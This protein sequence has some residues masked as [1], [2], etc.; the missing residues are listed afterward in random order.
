VRITGFFD[1]RN[2]EAE[3]ELKLAT[4]QRQGDEEF[5][6]H[7]VVDRTLIVDGERWIIDFKTSRKNEAQTEEAFIAAQVEEY[8][9]QLESY[10]SLFNGLE[11]KPQRLALFLT[12]ID[13]LVE[14]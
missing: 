4:R 11:N 5:H 6:K 2:A 1:S 8:R 13:K 12:A 10:G 7:R 3:S 14:I 9:T